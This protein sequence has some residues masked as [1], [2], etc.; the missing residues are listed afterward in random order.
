[1]ELCPKKYNKPNVNYYLKN[2]FIDRQ[3]VKK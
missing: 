1:M 3:R 2:E